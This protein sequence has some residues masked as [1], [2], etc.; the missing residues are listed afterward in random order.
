MP[1]TRSRPRC[2]GDPA[3]P[4]RS[5][6]AR[7]VAVVAGRAR[8]G[9][10]PPPRGLRGVLAPR[11]RRATPAGSPTYL[12]GECRIDGRA[13]EAAGW[14]AR[15]RRLLAGCEP[16]AELGWLAVEEAK[17]AADPAVAETH[18]RARADA[19]A[20][21]R[22]PRHR[23]HG[24]RPARPRARGARAGGRGHGAPGRGD[25]RRARAASRSDPLACGDACCTT[26]VV[27]DGLADLDRAD[28][29][30]RGRRRVHRAPPLHPGPVLVSRRSS[31]RVLIRAGEWARAEAVL[32]EAL[33][34]RAGPPPRRGPRPAARDPGRPAAPPR[35]AA[36]RPRGCS[37]ASRTSRSRSRRSSASTSREGE[38]GDGGRAARTR[39]TESARCVR[40]S[41]AR[42][43]ATPPPR[44]E[45]AARLA[46]L[47]AATAREDLAAEAPLA[48]DAASPPR[49]RTRDR[50]S[51]RRRDRG[52]A[53][54]GSRA[55][56]RTPRGGSPRSSSP[57]RRRGRGS[58]SRASQAA[59]G[60]PLAR[61][62]R[63]RRPRRRSRRS[64][65]RPVADAAGAL[66]RDARRVRAGDDARRARRAHRARGGG[67]AADRGRSLQRG[68]RRAARDR[69]QDRR[70]PREP[71]AGEARRAQPGRRGRSTHCAKASERPWASKTPSGS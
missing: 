71:G 34:R 30:V 40:R 49:P 55:C 68:D 8:R 35:P 69:A 5:G 13:A 41:R 20:R 26:L 43:S 19:R 31:A 28:P 10:R 63:A 67:S 62:L 7:A 37:R 70:A 3:R 2:R 17:R 23:V 9:D 1:G 47:A 50:A 24:A 42:V 32:T 27:C 18:A 60:S 22:R 14:M 46:R 11:R 59:A 64:G 56:S 58:R 48:L 39:R 33:A 16:C 57:T 21:D 6:R 25:D 54:R 12:A 61:R 53:E 44:R 38:I 51:A 66:L 65:P 45:S 36:R 4:V 52:D 15:A 29:V